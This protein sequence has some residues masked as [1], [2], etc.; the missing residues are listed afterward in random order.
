MR[1]AIVVEQSRVSCIVEVMPGTQAVRSILSNAANGAVDQPRVYLFE[2]LIP[3]VQTIHNSWPEAFEYHISLTHQAQE[4]FMPF[5]RLQVQGHTALIA[6][7]GHEV[8]AL[9]SRLL[10][11]H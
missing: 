8:Q 4:D 11:R 5:L 1:S 6:V 3:K 2:L 10:W 9:T 7:D